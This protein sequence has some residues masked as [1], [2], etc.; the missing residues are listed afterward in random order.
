MKLRCVLVW[1]AASL[2]LAAALF[3]Q[4]QMLLEAFCD[5]MQATAQAQAQQLARQ[6]AAEIVQAA[7]E[8]STA[9][10]TAPETGTGRDEPDGSSGAERAAASALIDEFLV[11]PLVFELMEKTDVL[12]CAVTGRDRLLESQV[13]Q[14]DG[15]LAPDTDLP[16]TRAAGHAQIAAGDGTQGVQVTVVLDDALWQTQVQQL[17]D[18]SLWKSVALAQAGAAA[19]FLLGLCLLAPWR[20]KSRG[21][22]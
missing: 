10:G 8:I 20:S 12:A 5:D 18:K 14:A 2:L 9:S 16:R 4:R 17:A 22:D 19:F 15:S 11:R 21:T 7:D 13:R 6:L 3:V 1:L